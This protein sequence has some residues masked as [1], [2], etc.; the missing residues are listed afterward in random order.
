M[1]YSKPLTLFIFFMLTFKVLYSCLYGVVT[2]FLQ[3][4]FLTGKIVVNWLSRSLRLRVVATCDTKG[5]IVLSQDNNPKKTI[6][7]T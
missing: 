4:Q 5:R 1:N 7:I 6:I 3:H 2:K